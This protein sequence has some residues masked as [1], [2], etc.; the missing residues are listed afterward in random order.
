[1]SRA[2]RLQ[3]PTGG[4]GACDRKAA[5]VKSHVRSLIDDSNSVTT[6][7]EFL[8]AILS[9]CGIGGVRVVCRRPKCNKRP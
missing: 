2:G 6:P 4:K 8:E 1:M 9:H 3:R 5:Q 7:E